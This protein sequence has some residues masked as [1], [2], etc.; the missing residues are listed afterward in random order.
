LEVVRTCGLAAHAFLSVPAEAIAGLRQ[1]PGPVVGEPLPTTFLKH[2]DEQTVVGLAAVYQAIDDHA[3]A[4]A[5]AARPFADW[6]VVAAP[7]FIGRAALAQALPRFV[8]EGAWGVSPHLI[9][10]R[11]LHSMS[12]AISLALKAHGPNFRTSASAAAP[13]ARARPCSPA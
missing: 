11:S 4:P 2:A 12:G 7:R 13:A 6:A 9:P 5:G 1:R 10:H 8:R 3:L